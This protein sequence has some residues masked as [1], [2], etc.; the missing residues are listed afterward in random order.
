MLHAT[1]VADLRGGRWRGVLIRGRS[2]VGKS[3]LALALVEQGWRLVADDRVIVW[4]SAHRVWGRAPSSL[5]GLVEARGLGIAAIPALPWCEVALVADLSAAAAP[6][7]ERLPEAAL[8]EIA[9][10]SLP[11]HT[12]AADAPAASLR[13]RLALA[14]GFDSAAMGR[15]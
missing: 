1:L 13:L 11:R 7:A 2:G 12:L 8:A 14:G 9:G 15:I 6:S 3:A 5:A 10:M 4:R